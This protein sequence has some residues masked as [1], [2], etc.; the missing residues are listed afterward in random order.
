MS[1][2]PT[3]NHGR[4][5][6]SGVFQTDNAA[7]PPSALKPFCDIARRHVSYERE[8]MEAVS[9]VLRSGGFIKGPHVQRFESELCSITGAKHAIGC[10]N[11]T[12]ALELSLR[13]LGIGPGHG[14][15]VPAYTFIASAGAIHNV[16]AVPI[17][18]DIDPRTLNI[19]AATA[20]AALEVATNRW[21]S[22]VSPRAIMAVNIFGLPCEYDELRTLAQKNSLLI[23]EDGAQS[24]GATYRGSSSGTLGDISTFSFFPAKPFGGFEDGGA[25]L[26]GDDKIARRVRQ[27]ADHGFNPSTLAYGSVGTNSRLSTLHA[28]LLSVALQH[29]PQLAQRRED[30]SQRY[31]TE[32]QDYF[33][34]QSISSHTKS[35]NAQFALIIEGENPEQQRNRLIDQLARIGIEG[36]MYYVD[37]LHLQP[38]FA[39]LDYRRGD[40][41][42]YEDI[43]RRAINIPNDPSSLTDSDVER[44]IKVLSSRGDD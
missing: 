33:L 32:L 24:F 9:E 2:Q 41:P 26:C 44:I 31:R 17:F 40:L 27:L 28:A 16:G 8:L 43:C 10:A 6:P 5:S 30:I 18:A 23:I 1:A 21:G 19:S 29:F 25:V 3:Q 13:A 34:L 11:G 35:A 15:V 12:S 36:R 7:N 4:N 20:E 14:V 22:A 42:T 38:A 37:P 39:H